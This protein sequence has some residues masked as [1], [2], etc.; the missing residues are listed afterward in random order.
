M[1]GFISQV[2]FKNMQP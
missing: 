1:V 2:F